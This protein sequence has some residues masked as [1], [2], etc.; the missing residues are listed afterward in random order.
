[1]NY[2]KDIKLIVQKQI[3]QQT[4]SI[5]I[6]I[7]AKNKHQVLKKWEIIAINRLIMILLTKSI[8]TIISNNYKLIKIQIDKLKEII[9]I[10]N[11]LV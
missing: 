4:R 8:K 3:G 7:L 10:S 11:S 9:P 5:S 2:Y 1:M 6:K